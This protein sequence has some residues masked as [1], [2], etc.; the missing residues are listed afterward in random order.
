MSNTLSSTSDCSQLSK[1]HVLVDA[2]VGRMVR[3]NT[4]ERFAVLRLRW[5]LTSARLQSEVVDGVGKI[6]V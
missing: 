1:R 5:F 3:V 4:V 2:G 6:I